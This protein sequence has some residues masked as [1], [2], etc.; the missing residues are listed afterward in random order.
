MM[1]DQE[2]IRLLFDTGHLN[3]PKGKGKVVFSYGETTLGTLRLNSMGV[4]DAIASYQDFM[5]QSLEPLSMAHHS[6]PAIVDG[7]IGPATRELLDMPRCGCPDYGHAHDHYG[8]PVQPAV[9]TGN[10]PRCHDIG[11][12]HAATVYVD[13]SGMP[14]FLKP[15]FDEVWKRTVAAYDEIGL[16]FIRVDDHDDANIDFSF[17]N[18]SN[19][20]IGLA[21]VGR[22][23]SCGS[24]IWCRY[25]AKYKPSNVVGS[26]TELVMHELGHNCGLNHSRGGIMNPSLITG[27]PASWDRDPSES[28]LKRYY[29]G[30]PIPTG[31]DGK[32]MWT[33]QGLQTNRGREQWVP[34]S[35]P[36]PISGT[37]EELYRG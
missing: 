30:K 32:E 9:G 11:D 1:T 15:V 10:W 19:G 25:L 17:V 21:I 13:E 27:L 6:R 31:P 22:G 28:I 37:G 18:R 2:I 4:V 5:G 34:L 24:Q 14:S 36:I 12:F 7:R 23:Q 35:V 26:W 16:R 20:W 8:E 29:G 3:Y 33:R